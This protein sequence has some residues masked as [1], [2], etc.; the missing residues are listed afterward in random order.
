MFRHRERR[1]KSEKA[2]VAGDPSHRQTGRNPEESIK[3]RNRKEGIERN[4]KESITQRNRKDGIERINSRE[5]KRI[6]KYIESEIQET[7]INF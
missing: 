2:D 3:Q 4:P 6:S 5:L 7:N 1:E